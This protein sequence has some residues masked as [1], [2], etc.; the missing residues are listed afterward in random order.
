MESVKTILAIDDNRDILY[1]LEQIFN[2]QGWRPLLANGY[3]EAD[4]LIKKEKIDLILVDYHMP[5]V[6]GISAVK[7][8]RKKLPKVPII[9]L[10]I[11]EE[12]RIVSK[13]MAAGA[14]D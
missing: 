2:F 11:E 1:T 10:T 14:D 4:K 6:D 3:E 8:I 5:G 7:E 9:V 12:D 13:I